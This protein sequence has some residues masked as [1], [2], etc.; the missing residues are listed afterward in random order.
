MTPTSIIVPTFCEAGN[1]EPLVTRITASLAPNHSDHEII[2][3]DDNSNDGTDRA[4]EKLRG[5][6]H[7]VRLIVRPHER[8]LSSA[9]IRGFN[10]A[11]GNI[12][13][14]MDADL[15][16]PPEVIPDL[17]E[18]LQDDEV[19]F[20]IGSRYVEGAGTDTEWG[21]FRQLNSSIATMMARPFTQA[22]DPMSGFFAIRRETYKN[23]DRL[24]PTGYKIGLELIVKCNCRNVREV[25]I[26]FAQRRCGSSKLTLKQ[27]WLYVG[28]VL[29]LARYKMTRS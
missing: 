24:H 16:H 13:V 5:Q 2:L 26:H 11:T 23:A 19:D 9:V 15:S 6:G 1:V 14:C 10:E 20:V 12:L 21:L 17:L 8:G 3:V 4:V 28:H 7:A 25:P 18:A 22:R 29:R 27:Q